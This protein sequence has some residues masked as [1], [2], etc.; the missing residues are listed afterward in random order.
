MLGPLIAGMMLQMAGGTVSVPRLPML[1]AQAILGCLVARLMTP[2]ILAGFAQHWVVCIGVVAASIAASVTIGWAM[3]RWRILPGNTAVWG[4]LPGGAMVMIVMAR[5][6]GADFRLVAFMQYLRVVLVAIAASAVALLFVHGD[7]GRFA[8]S[9]FPPVHWRA[10]AATAII[11]LAGSILGMAVRIPAG[12]LLGPLVVGAVFNLLG[13]VDIELP[14]SVLI[15]SFALIGWTVGLRFTP[16]V[17]AAAARSLP[18]ATCATVLLIAFCGLLA[19]LL[20]A[21]MHVDPLTAYLATSPGGVDAALVIGGAAN[22]DLGFIMVLQM[23]RLIL[24]LAAGPAVARFVAG[25]L[26]SRGARLRQ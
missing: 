8:P 19:W 21:I 23:V 10:L 25:M 11:A 26:E 20:V 1:A 12:I 22:A 16:E 3:S 2:G 14:P 9:Y 17:L 18:Q 5:A 13:W 7:A 6:Y 24:L 15:M 4:M